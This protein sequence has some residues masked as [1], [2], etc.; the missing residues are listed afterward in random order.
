[1]LGRGERAT[2]ALRRGVTSSSSLVVRKSV[3]P[4]RKPSR[5]VWPC[6]L[7]GARRGPNGAALVAGSSPV[8][9]VVTFVLTPGGREGSRAGG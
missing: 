3:K 4:P 9:L 5:Y 2:L 1:M 7:P 8:D 6:P